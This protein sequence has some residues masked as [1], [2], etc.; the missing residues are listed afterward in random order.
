MN[1]R[2]VLEKHRKGEIDASEAEKLLRL[3]Y[4]ERIAGHTPSTFAGPVQGRSRD[5]LRGEQ[6]P[7]PSP[8]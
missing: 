7:V 1:I 6:A 3:D 5:N 8:I 4:I 2:D